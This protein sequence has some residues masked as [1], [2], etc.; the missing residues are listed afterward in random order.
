MDNIARNL[1]VTDPGFE[2]EFPDVSMQLRR[3]V[4]NYVDRV[5]SKAGTAGRTEFVSSD[6]IHLHGIPSIALNGNG[7]PVLPENPG[8]T[9]R[10][11]KVGLDKYLRQY[12]GAHLCEF[13]M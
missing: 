8:T 9:L 10:L 11:T 13:R 6:S 1:K 4:V 2:A 12:I 5:S 7:Y 3:A